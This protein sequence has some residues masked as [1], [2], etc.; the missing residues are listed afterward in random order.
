[1]LQWMNTHP[2]VDGQHN[3]DLV[4][5]KNTSWMGKDKGTDMEGVN[6]QKQRR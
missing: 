2:E 1:M 5:F 6:Q 4:F 3:L